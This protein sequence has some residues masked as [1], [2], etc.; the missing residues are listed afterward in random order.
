M[1]RVSDAGKLPASAIPVG[2]MLAKGAFSRI[3]GA[4][5]A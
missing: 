3:T 1:M 2:A 4:I 5:K